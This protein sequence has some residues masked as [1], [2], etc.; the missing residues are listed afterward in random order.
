MYGRRG[1][2]R[3]KGDFGR[4]IMGGGW[5]R[6]VSE[7]KEEEEKEEVE[8]KEELLKIIPRLYRYKY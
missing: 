7:D 3:E 4:K 8:E 6:G 1:D 2:E 5:G